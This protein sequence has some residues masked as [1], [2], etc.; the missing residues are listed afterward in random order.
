MIRNLLTYGRGP[1]VNTSENEQIQPERFSDSQVQLIGAALRQQ[2]LSHTD[3]V[4]RQ[5]ATQEATQILAIM[6][7]QEFF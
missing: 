5:Q 1:A 2:V 6:S 4:R 7:N 3:R